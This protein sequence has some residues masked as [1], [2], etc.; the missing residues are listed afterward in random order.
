MCGEPCLV[1]DAESAASLRTIH[2][3]TAALLR[4]LE[5]TGP[6]EIHSLGSELEGHFFPNQ[7]PSSPSFMDLSL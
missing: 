6:S 2:T 7:D 5:N 1:T 4:A 3:T